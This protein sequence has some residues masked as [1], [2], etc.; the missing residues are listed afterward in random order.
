MKSVPQGGVHI[1]CSPTQEIVHLE[2]LLG[3]SSSIYQK[4]D[5]FMLPHWNCNIECYSV[6]AWAFVQRRFAF[7]ESIPD[8]DKTSYSFAF[9]CN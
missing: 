8:I 3:P 4:C 7:H 2:G 9:N 1:D 6:C 5:D